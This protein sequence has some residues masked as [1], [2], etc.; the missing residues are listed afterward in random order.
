MELNVK[1]TPELAVVAVVFLPDYKIFAGALPAF[2]FA[3]EVDEQEPGSINWV[4]VSKPDL[5][6]VY[7]DTELQLMMALSQ[8][9]EGFTF[10]AIT[11]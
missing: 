6:Y 4:C 10:N 8:Y 9:P 1:I 11:R 2:Q 5:A 3:N 7:R